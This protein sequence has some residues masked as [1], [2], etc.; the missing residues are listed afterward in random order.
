MSLTSDRANNL[1][2]YLMS[3][4]E[5]SKELLESTPEEALKR[6]N[7]AGHDFTLEEI[8]Q[9]GQQLR[10]AVSGEL[11]EDSLEEVAG[12]GLGGTFVAGFLV[13]VAIG[14]AVITW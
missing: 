8:L 6:I 11:S 2:N 10:E 5:L 7:A 4:P 3:N 9:F 14:C 1:A 12:G 13:G